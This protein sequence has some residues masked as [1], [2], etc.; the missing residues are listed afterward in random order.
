M[1][2]LHATS[3]LTVK[4]SN[5]LH[6]CIWYRKLSIASRHIFP[7]PSCPIHQKKIQ[8]ARE[9]TKVLVHCT[10]RHQASLT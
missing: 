7:S 6:S 3:E 9:T 2:K 10:M 5:I 1:Q 8:L 4:I